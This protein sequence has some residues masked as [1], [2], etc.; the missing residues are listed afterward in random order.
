[1]V[2]GAVYRP[3]LLMV[4]TTGV[5]V[6]STAGLFAFLTIAVNV[7]VCRSSNETEVGKTEMLIEDTETTPPPELT[8]SSF[9]AGDA[10]NESPN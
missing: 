5:S 8:G 1:M 7:C 10:A 2:D 6:H 4:P 9:P 3:L